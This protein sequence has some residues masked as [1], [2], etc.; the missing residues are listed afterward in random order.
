MSLRYTS[1]TFVHNSMALYLKLGVNVFL[2][3][4]ICLPQ[5]IVPDLPFV[6]LQSRCSIPDV[7]FALRK[8]R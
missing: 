3:L 2:A 7:P 6:D 1:T 8:I 4:L 5:Y